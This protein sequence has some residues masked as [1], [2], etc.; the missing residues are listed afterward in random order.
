MTWGMALII[1]NVW[2]AAAA[3]SRFW[4]YFLALFWLVAAL[5]GVR[6]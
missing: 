1:S 3:E 6:P 2:F 4:K 5:L